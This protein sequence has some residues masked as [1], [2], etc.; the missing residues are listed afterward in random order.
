MESAY[1]KKKC[2]KH[3]SNLGKKLEFKERKNG[4]QHVQNNTRGFL[5][6]ESYV[7]GKA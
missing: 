4:A 2:H 1:K 5:N 6:W 7:N 3:S